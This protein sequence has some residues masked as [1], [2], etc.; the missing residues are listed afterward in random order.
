MRNGRS[1]R[2]LV[3]PAQAGSE[4]KARRP[5]VRAGALA[6]VA[7]VAGLGGYG[8]VR[9]S[10]VA[11]LR[12]E[13]D[14]P[15]DVRAEVD[16][17]W[18]RFEAVFGARRRCYEDVTLLL[19]SEL[20]GGD[21]RYLIDDARIEIKIPTSPHRFR[22]SL[23]HELAHH[24]EHTCSAF[25]ELRRDFQD[26]PAVSDGDWSTGHRWQEVPSELWAETVVE[27]VNGERVRYGRTMPLPVGAIDAVQAWATP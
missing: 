17:T 26:L 24:V 2:G 19:V 6:M 1:E 8:T 11:T 20:D 3:R 4:R 15:T 13:Q 14:L 16:A 21:A 22:D 18:D 27:L 9:R 10:Q 25:D 7:L 5:F 23:A 12:A